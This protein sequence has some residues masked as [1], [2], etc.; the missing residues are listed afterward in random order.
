ME[1]REDLLEAQRYRRAQCADAMFGV[2]PAHA[3]Y[4]GP[5]PWVGVVL[6]LLV[7]GVLGAADPVIGVMTQRPATSAPAA[8]PAPQVAPDVPEHDVRGQDQNDAPH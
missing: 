5:G 7:A 4:T 3:L 8:P 1:R 6:G 2:G